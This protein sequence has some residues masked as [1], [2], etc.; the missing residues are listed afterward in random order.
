MDLLEP[1]TQRFL[2][3]KKARRVGGVLVATKNSYPLRDLLKRDS[4]NKLLLVK[5][6]DTNPA[7]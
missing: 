5:Q 3:L 7:Q 1:L 2:R 4:C 6:S